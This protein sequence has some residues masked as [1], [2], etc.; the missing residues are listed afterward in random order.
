MPDAPN[1]WR[2]LEASCETDGRWQAAP[3]GQT[4]EATWLEHWRREH[5]A[6]LVKP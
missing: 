2:C 6:H 5:A 4:A 1:T 3:P